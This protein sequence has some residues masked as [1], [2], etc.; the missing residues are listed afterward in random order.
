MNRMCPNMID[1]KAT[2]YCISDHMTIVSTCAEYLNNSGLVM[3]LLK[4]KSAC[5]S[6]L[7]RRKEGIENRM[8]EEIRQK[9]DKAAN[10][11]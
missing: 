9:V 11:K 4:L 5:T 1:V 7:N 8:T 2:Q 3:L 10:M 6:T